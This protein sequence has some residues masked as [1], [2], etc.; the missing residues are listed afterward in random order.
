LSALYARLA[1]WQ[2][3]A[4]VGVVVV[5]RDGLESFVMTIDRIFIVFMASCGLILA[6][7]VLLFPQSRDIGIPPYFWV[8]IPM[9]IFEAVAFARN[10]GAP[11][12]VI[13]METRLIGFVIAIVLMLV[14][15]YLA[16]QPMLQII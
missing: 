7:I 9:A 4:R 12:S 16:G 11:G 3:A 13:A 1:E 8:L 6:G 5:R 14:I 10:R 15:P 2:S